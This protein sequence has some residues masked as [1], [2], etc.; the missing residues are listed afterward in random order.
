ML[1]L[2]LVLLSLPDRERAGTLL[3]NVHGVDGIL[4]LLNRV[5]ELEFFFIPVGPGAELAIRRRCIVRK[6]TRTF[7]SVRGVALLR[8]EAFTNFTLQIVILIYSFADPRLP[9]QDHERNLPHEQLAEVLEVGQQLV[10]EPVA[11]H[12]IPCTIEDAVLVDAPL[13]HFNVP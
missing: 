12:L 2:I 13:E 5:L 10:S 7:N 9:H 4:L 1:R 11:R 6:R 8:G 3:S